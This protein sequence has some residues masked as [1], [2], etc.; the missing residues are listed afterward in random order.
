MISNKLELLCRTSSDDESE[1]TAKKTTLDALYLD[2]NAY[3]TSELVLFSEF[4][5]SV[6]QLPE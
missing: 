6:S 5:S 2:C 4:Q 1:I 3:I